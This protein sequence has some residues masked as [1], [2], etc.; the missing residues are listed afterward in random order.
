MYVLMFFLLVT[1][2]VMLG[3]KIMRDTSYRQAMA[4][5]RSGSSYVEAQSNALRRILPGP[6]QQYIKGFERAAADWE[7]E[8]P[9]WRQSGDLVSEHRAL[10]VEPG[11]HRK[12][13][14]CAEVIKSEAVVCRFC[15]RD[16]P[17]LAN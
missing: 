13:P 16:L 9:G 10:G 6:R 11:A 1:G 12:C 7:R 17:A 5:F 15:R 2:G 4:A 3:N 14:F 8:R